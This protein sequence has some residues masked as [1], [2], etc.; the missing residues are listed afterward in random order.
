MLHQQRI[1]AEHPAAVHPPF[2]HHPLALAVHI[3]LYAVVD[4]GN[5]AFGIF[6]DAELQPQ[7][8]LIPAG[9]ALLDKRAHAHQLSLEFS[10][11]GQ[12]FSG[13]VEEYGGLES[14]IDNADQY[15]GDDGA[16][17]GQLYN[18]IHWPLSPSP[19]GIIQGRLP[20][21][22]AGAADTPQAPPAGIV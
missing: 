10:R 3:R 21:F 9:A 14:L 6:G 16:T 2:H 4:H 12:N 15:G 11:G 19:G 17:D 20:G 5:Q 18:S 13:G 7:G 8:L 1:G 22:A